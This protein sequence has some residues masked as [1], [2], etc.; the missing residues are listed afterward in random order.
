MSRIDFSR[1]IPDNFVKVKPKEALNELLLTNFKDANL[2]LIEA[3]AEFNSELL[4]N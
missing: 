4:N 1:V 2:I 3:P